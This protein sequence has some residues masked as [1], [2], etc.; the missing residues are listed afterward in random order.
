MFKIVESLFVRINRHTDKSQIHLYVLYI[1]T[2]THIHKHMHVPILIHKHT[3]TYTHI[4]THTYTYIH[5][6]MHIRIFIHIILCSH[7]FFQCL[8]W[9]ISLKFSMYVCF[10]WSELSVVCCFNLCSRVQENIFS[11]YVPGH[12]TQKLSNVSCSSFRDVFFEWA[13][14][15]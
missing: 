7:V 13:W 10:P 8:L 4:H 3:H 14:S 6:H 5:I 15:Q 12:A 9:N 2:H 1:Y 11:M